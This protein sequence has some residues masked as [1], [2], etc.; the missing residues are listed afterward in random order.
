MGQWHACHSALTAATTAYLMDN[1]HDQRTLGIETDSLVNMW[2]VAYPLQIRWKESDLS[3][4]AAATATA[5]GNTASSTKSPMSSIESPAAASASSSS[6]LPHGL[7][8]G[9][10]AGIGVGVAVGVIAMALALGWWI[11]RRRRN[12]Q[13]IRPTGQAEEAVYTKPEMDGAGAARAG[14]PVAELSASPAAEKHVLKPE[15][16]GRADPRP[17]NYNPVELEKLPGSRNYMAHPAIAALEARIKAGNHEDVVDDMWVNTAPLY[18]LLADGFTVAAQSRFRD[19][20]GKEG[21][22]GVRKFVNGN[23]R[24]VVF[25]DPFYEHQN[26]ASEW[27]SKRAQLKGYLGQMRMAEPDFQKMLFGVI[28][29]GKASQFFSY[30]Y[31]QSELRCLHDGSEAYTFKNHQAE[32]DRWMTYMRDQILAGN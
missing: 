29:I 20:S 28:T 31:L 25:E 15:L 18:F 14:R 19:E 21:G 17:V 24:V 27:A 3:A 9:A 1:L 4:F 8:T 30:P 5:T 13:A 6:D 2:H 23:A 32:V 11:F 16:D 10:A 7:S 26:Q 22:I 12:T